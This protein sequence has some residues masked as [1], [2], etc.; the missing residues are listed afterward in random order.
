MAV[1]IG[2]IEEGTSQI[3]GGCDGAKRFF[4]IC[5]AVAIAK[6]VATDSPGAKTYLRDFQVGRS[7]LAVLHERLMVSSRR[8][9][10]SGFCGWRSFMRSDADGEMLVSCHIGPW[11]N[12]FA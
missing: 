12:R 9:S 8:G 1:H 4:V 10:G 5:R 6:L 7:E 3:N 11:P 2:R